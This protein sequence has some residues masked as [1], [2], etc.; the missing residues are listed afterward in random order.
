[1]G[2]GIRV[3]A[4]LWRLCPEH[5]PC[6]WHIRTAQQVLNESNESIAVELQSPCFSLVP[7][8]L[9]HEDDL[10]GEACHKLSASIWVVQGKL[11][12]FLSL[13]H[14]QAIGLVRTF[15]PVSSG[16]FWSQAFFH[17]KTEVQPESWYQTSSGLQVSRQGFLSWISHSLEV[18]VKKTMSPIWQIYY[19]TDILPEKFR[20]AP[21]PKVSLLLLF[22]SWW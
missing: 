2:E 15:H 8:Y 16:P 20:E 3:R 7:R 14:S 10:L 9:P 22:L 21:G 11:W 19:D 6:A 12:K 18:G 17:S 1:M 4:L 5:I 13:L